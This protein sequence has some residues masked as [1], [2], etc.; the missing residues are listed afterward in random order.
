MRSL[1][2]SSLLFLVTGYQL[3]LFTYLDSVRPRYPTDNASTVL[4]SIYYTYSL[5][6]YSSVIRYPSEVTFTFAKRRYWC[7]T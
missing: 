4:L 2:T 1:Y 3:T 5:D 6:D 7:R